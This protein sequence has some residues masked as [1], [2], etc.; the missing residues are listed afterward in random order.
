VVGA[1]S[2]ITASATQA[3]RTV[4]ILIVSLCPPVDILGSL[5]LLARATATR[6]S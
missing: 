3:G 5:A 6:L 4:P 2:S 1:P